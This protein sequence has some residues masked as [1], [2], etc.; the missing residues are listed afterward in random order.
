MKIALISVLGTDVLMYILPIFFYVTYKQ[1]KR[2]YQLVVSGGQ[3]IVL[4]EWEDMICHNAF[5]TTIGVMINF[6]I[7]GF[8]F[9]ISISFVAVWSYQASAWLITWIVSFFMDFILFEF[10]VELIIG[11]IYIKRKNSSCLRVVAEFLNSARNYR[12][13]WP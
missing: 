10:L 13:L 8:A 12:C 2:L 5:Y 3:L 9:Y 7:W 1:R 4:K 6:G 11:L